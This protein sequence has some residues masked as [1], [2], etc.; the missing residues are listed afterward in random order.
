VVT[1]A[2]HVVWVAGVAVSEDFRLGPQTRSTAVLTARVL[3]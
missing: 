1:A 2:G 3:D